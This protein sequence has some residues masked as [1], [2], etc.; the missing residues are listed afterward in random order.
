MGPTTVLVIVVAALGLLVAGL[1]AALFQVIRQQGRLLLR[2]EQMERK[3]GFSPEDSV[4]RGTVALQA[5]DPAG[6]PVGTA[7][8]D[9]ELPV[10]SGG[11]VTLAGLRGR[12]LLLVSWSA[13]CG[14]CDRIAPDL[15]R[16]RPLLERAGTA[17]LLV[18][19]AGEA[20]ER[21]LAE[22]SG[23]TGS[24]A[25]QDDGPEVLE[26]FAPL[27]TP[28]AYL[29][30]AEGRVAAPLALGADQVLALAEKATGAQSTSH[31]VA[32]ATETHRIPPAG[33]A[34]RPLA[35]SRIERDGL[36]PGVP[37]PTFVLPEARGGQV[38]LDQYRGRKVLL[39]FSDPHC[40]PCEELSPH[41][42]RIAAVHQGN[43]LAVV[44]IGRGDAEENRRKAE[45]YGWDF[46][47]AVQ[48]RWEIS[49]SYG[50]FATPVAYRID[51]HGVIESG[52]AR[53]VEEILALVPEASSGREVAH[54]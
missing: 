44:V 29:L 5:R 41:L 11:T 51:E 38:A 13:R 3:L 33:L 34:L 14:F 18:G 39:V 21:E 19:H 40:G 4:A 7:L 46:P 35:E 12:S 53:G 27:G 10:A 16:L 15:A 23:L 36:R 30:D 45:R 31:G 9:F 42:A 54:G 20:A 1:T 49:R 47:V 2:I 6:L 43:G 37:A 32:S 17:L 28:A 48:R 25:L 24:L 50:I 8:P 26:A 22:S 52:V